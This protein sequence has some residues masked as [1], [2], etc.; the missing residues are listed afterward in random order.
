MR[1]LA[2][3]YCRINYEKL[4]NYE[5]IIQDVTLKELGGDGIAGGKLVNRVLI[6]VLR[7]NR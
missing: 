5:E 3:I 4:R 1:R 7:K 2:L 6:I